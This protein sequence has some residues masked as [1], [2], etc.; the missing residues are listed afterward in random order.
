SQLTCR[1]R[2]VDLKGRAVPAVGLRASRR[3]AFR[4]LLHYLERC[5]FS[6][7]FLIVRSANPPGR[8]GAMSDLG[9]CTTRLEFSLPLPLA[10]DIG[11]RRVARCAVGT[12][13]PNPN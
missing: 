6:F 2:L 1:R 10:S 12:P 4:T 8:I 11:K 3:Q 13:R 5:D 9:H 7:A